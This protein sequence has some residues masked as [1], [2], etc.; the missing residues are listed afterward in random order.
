MPIVD[1]RLD[2][3]VVRVLWTDRS[4]G[5]L[6]LGV[7]AQV[8]E[9]RRRAVVDRQ[10]VSVE[11][12][13]GAGVLVVD[14]ATDV[15][16]RDPVA[17]DAIVTSRDDIALSV[18]AADCATIALWSDDAVIGAV[19]CGWR[20][21]V[22]GVVEAAVG[23]MR[24][25]TDA[26][27]RAALGPSIGPECYEFGPEDLA[28]VRAAVGDVVVAATADGSPALDVRAGLRARLHAVGVD[29]VAED[30]RCTA[31]EPT[32]FFSHRARDETGRQALVVWIE[33]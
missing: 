26:P 10:W 27:V 25:R 29:L 28:T 11:Q 31:C 7:D 12:V 19:H 33:R 20:G 32:S 2:D 6:A 22:A 21:L 3:G 24:A 23:A 16:R 8:L 4:A 17:A 5:D 13:H 18:R 1:G 9:S 30:P 15:D 14:T